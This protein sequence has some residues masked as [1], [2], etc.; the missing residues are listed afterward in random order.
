LAQAAIGWLRQTPAQ[1]V[2][3]A[4]FVSILQCVR[5]LELGP[6]VMKRSILL[7]GGI[8]ALGIVSA[9][10][11]DS[12]PIRK[13]TLSGNSSSEQDKAAPGSLTESS[14]KTA[15]IVQTALE[16]EYPFYHTTTALQQEVHALQDKCHGALSIAKESDEGVNIDVIT[17]RKK[18]ASPINR[19]FFLFGEHS[20]ELISPESGAELLKTLCGK[21]GD[22]LS[23]LLEESEFQMILNG[24]PR[25]RV[26][27]EEGDYCLRTNPS[28]VDLN[29]NWDEK[30]TDE[31][32]PAAPAATN[33][34]P[35]PFSE[36]ETRIFR[37]VVSKFNPTTFVTVHSGT[38]GMYMPWAYDM[39][40]LA[41]FNQPAMLEVLRTLDKSYCQC[42]FGAA[43]REVGYPCPGTCLDWVYDNLKTPYVFA[44]EIYTSPENSESLQTRWEDE[45]AD[46]AMA[47]LQQGDH[48]G[49]EQFRQLFQEHPSDFVSL[50]QQKSGEAQ[51]SESCFRAFNP[52][53]E[54]EYRQVLQNWVSAYMDMSKLI[55]ARLK[56]NMTKAQV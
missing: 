21:E 7:L 54:A 43:G 13:V 30:W 18:G 56:A 16:A 25:S 32:L 11:L 42:P 52:T 41:Q 28:G 47:L 2:A 49:H 37:R 27:V 3:L 33:P 38:R 35:K 5:E 4:T 36:P 45:V 46:G 26:K 40:H 48:L 8:F 51:S 12:R 6:Q 53:Q 22:S 24:N 19:V 55:A 10:A 29:R 15:L 50:S 34:G 9:G 23:Q 20:R 44:F 17:L 1:R 14:H 31:E 39:E